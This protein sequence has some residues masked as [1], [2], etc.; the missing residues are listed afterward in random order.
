MDYHFLLQGNLPNPGIE[1]ASPA[2]AGRFFYH[3]ATYLFYLWAAYLF[4]IYDTFPDKD[5]EHLF[6][7]LLVLCVLA[8]HILCPFVDWVVYSLGCDP[9]LQVRNLSPRE[10]QWPSRQSVGKWQS[11]R[12]LSPWSLPFLAVEG[13]EVTV[14][15]ETQSGCKV[16]RHEEKAEIFFFLNIYIFY[17]S[18]VAL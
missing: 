8:I 10:R 2:V 4:N 6:M 16:L 7:C 15:W 3:W 9:F 1:I 12:F 18:I 13:D 5:V 11:P 14:S 17:W